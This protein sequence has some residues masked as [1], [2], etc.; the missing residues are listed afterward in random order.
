MGGLKPLHMSKLL[1]GKSQWLVCRS[2]WL[3]DSSWLV[4]WLDGWMVGW[5]G[6]GLVGCLVGWWLVWWVVDILLLRA[7]DR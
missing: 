6:G 3:F 4:S 1:K 7:F 2:L 5:L